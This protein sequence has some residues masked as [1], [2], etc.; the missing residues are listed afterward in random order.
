MMIDLHCHILPGLDDGAT[1]LQAAL[2]MAQ[3][4]AD[5]GIDIVVATPHVS[6]VNSLS[7]DEIRMAT[8]ALNEALQQQNIDLTIVPGAEVEAQPQLVKLLKSGQ[9]VTLGDNGTHL[10][11][12][13]AFVGVPQFLEQMCFELQVVGV[14]PVLAHPERS[15]LAVRQPEILSKLAE[16][17]CLLQVNASSILGQA[18]RRVKAIALDL[19]RSGQAQVLASDAHDLRYRPPQLSPARK[20]L[21]RVVKNIDFQMLVDRMPHGI[22]NSVQGEC[23]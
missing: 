16:R 20:E 4:A 21:E 17:G 1:D 14:T 10:L 18:G 6:S 22:I 8:Q 23:R 19:L 5:D 9:L 13:T 12:E 2:E 7:P 3:V 11:I 15:E